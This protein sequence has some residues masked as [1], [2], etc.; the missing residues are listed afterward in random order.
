MK[1]GRQGEDEI[2]LADLTG[3]GVQD[4]AVSAFVMEEAER[5]SLGRLLDV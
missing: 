4:A 3:V 2:T 1:P 5:R